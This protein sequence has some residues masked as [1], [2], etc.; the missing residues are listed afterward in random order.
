M[1]EIVFSESAKGSLKVAK[2][3]NGRKPATAAVGVILG[4]TDD[5]SKAMTAEEIEAA[6]LEFLER[7]NRA[8]EE[9]V[10]MD[11]GPDDVFSFSLCLSVGDISNACIEGRV[12]T[13][14]ELLSVWSPKEGTAQAA[15]QLARDKAD[16]ET[17]LERAIGKRESIRIWYSDSPDELCGLHWF[18]YQLRQQE[19]CNGAVFLVKLPDWEYNEQNNVVQ[20][21]TWGEVAPQ[22]FGKYTRLA[23]PVLP[24]LEG[25]FAFRWRELMQEN[26]PLRAVVNGR[27]RSMPADIYDSFIETE[28]AR[29]DD[30]FNEAI[31]IGNILGRHQLCIGDCQIALRIEEMIRTGKL[32]VV[33]PAADGDPIYRRILRKGTPHV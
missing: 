8:W 19:Q 17:V 4:D 26:A 1:I 24:P 20:H 27:L 21:M 16:F 29:M 13:L 25:A 9:A 15:E 5:P 28:V 23:R 14:A 2:S 12:E 22:E 33:T 31:L 18:M 3:F 7:H 6:K 11:G 10:T 30:T 32:S